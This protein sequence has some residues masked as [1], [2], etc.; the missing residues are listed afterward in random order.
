MY[1]Y[2]GRTRQGQI[3]CEDNLRALHPSKPCCHILPPSGH[4]GQAEW[5]HG[6][7]AGYLCRALS[8]TVA[9]EFC[10]A[11]LYGRLG[12][13]GSRQTGAAV[14]GSLSEAA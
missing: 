14:A 12:T 1:T 2:T 4:Q 13:C 11:C 10:Q 7:G 3:G 9:R 5:T 8:L 6:P